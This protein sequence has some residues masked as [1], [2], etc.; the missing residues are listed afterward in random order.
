[1]IPSLSATITI[2][3]SNDL[4]TMY[5]KKF[6][7]ETFRQGRKSFSV[8]YLIKMPDY[9]DLDIT[10]EFGNISV[11]ELSG[12]IKVKLSQGNFIAKR[13]TRGNASPL[14]SI[15]IDHGKVNI[16]ELNWMTLTVRNCPLVFI[17][18][19]QALLMTSEISKLKFREISSLVCNSKSDSYV[20]GSIKNI[21]SE[22][23]YSTIQIDTLY[24]R[25]KAGGTFGS[26]G[27]SYLNKEFSSIDIVMD[28]TSILIKT[29][30]DVSF[31]SDIIATNCFTDFPLKNNTGIIKTESNNIT[32]Y[33]GIAGAYRQ[34]NSMIKIRATSGRVTIQ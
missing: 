34:T 30:S 18:K 17:G 20:I 4:I 11:E 19:G 15:S 7:S 13:L 16:D 31:K 5:D 9:I 12:N 25:L 14:N 32:S 28:H 22:S 10:N 23:L 2:Q 6:F 26:L 21:V 3:D 27:I 8:D 33:V 1:M 24:G 29:G